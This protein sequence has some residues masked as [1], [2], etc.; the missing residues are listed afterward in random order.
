MQIQFVA[1]FNR[2]DN[3][4]KFI[5]W[6]NIANTAFQAHNCNPEFNAKVHQTLFKICDCCYQPFPKAINNSLKVV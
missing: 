6:A 1:S 4:V 2:F 3:P 5:K